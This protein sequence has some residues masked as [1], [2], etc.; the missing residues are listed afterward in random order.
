M[1]PPRTRTQIA[2]PC[3]N[4]DSPAGVS[5]EI[6]KRVAAHL[7]FDTKFNVKKALD[8][9]YSSQWFSVPPT[10]PHGQRPLLGTLHPSMVRAVQAAYKAASP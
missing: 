8:L 3:R 4:V 7:S 2:F 1:P 6:T 10:A 9:P 5:R